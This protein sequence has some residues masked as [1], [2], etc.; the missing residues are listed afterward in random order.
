MLSQEVYK[1][2]CQTYKSIWDYLRSVSVDRSV[3]IQNICSL[4]SYDIDRMYDTLDSVG[5]VFVDDSKFKKETLA[6]IPDIP[7]LSQNTFGL[8]STTGEFLLS[9]RFI[10]PVRDMLGNIVALIGWF[11]DE[12][13]YITTPSALFSKEGMFFGMEQLSSVGIGKD[14]VLVEGI[15]DSISVR[16]LGL[17]CVAEM[18][19][20]SSRYKETLYKLFRRVVAIPDNDT[21]G[22][23]VISEDKW[24]LPIGGRYFRWTGAKGIKDIDDLIKSFDVEDVK[25]LISDIF[26]ETDRVVSVSLV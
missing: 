9:G 15:F 24:R 20:V 5:F 11:P 23:K 6:S 7:E 26:N 21:E 18:G 4:R 14:F 25:G 17:N 13:K 22:R 1:T 3:V 8:L 12:K 19:I 10:F 2:Y 16:S